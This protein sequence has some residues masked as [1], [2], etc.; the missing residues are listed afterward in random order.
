M[1][2]KL[3]EWNSRLEDK[4]RSLEDAKEAQKETLDKIIKEHEDQLV[5]I[6]QKRI[7]LLED[8]STLEERNY[9][10][11]RSLDEKSD[12]EDKLRQENA[13]LKAKLYNLSFKTTGRATPPEVRRSSDPS[14]FNNV[15]CL[16]D[17]ELSNRPSITD[18]F[19]SSFAKNK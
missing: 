15:E 13:I 5:E 17:V 18:I 9:F 8:Y 16:D 3:T 7:A 2:T 12:V 14:P 10:L 4:C 11:Q 1:T 19:K 6:T